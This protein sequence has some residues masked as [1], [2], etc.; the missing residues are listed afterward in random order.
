MGILKNKIFIGIVVCLVIG[1]GIFA[2]HENTRLNLAHS[3]FENYYAF[4]GC[5]QLIDRTDTYGHCKTGDGQTIKIVKFQGAWYLDG[6][7][8]M[9]FGNFCL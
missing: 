7:L 3:T 4:R 5:T 8:P 6:D 2:L 9:C 1:G